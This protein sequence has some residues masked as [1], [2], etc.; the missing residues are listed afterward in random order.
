MVTTQ[1]SL[2]RLS[3]LV[4]VC[5]LSVIAYQLQHT[6]MEPTPSIESATNV[7][8]TRLMPCCTDPMTGFY[9]DGNCLTGQQDHGTH[10]VCAVM[11]QEFLEYTRSVGNDLTTPRPEYQFPGLKPGDLWC[12]CALRW[13]EAYKDGK[14][15]KVVLQSTHSKTLDYI[16]LEE[17][18][19]YAHD[20]E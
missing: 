10:T 20:E 11:T 8:G 16:S 9:R 14:A 2:I 19:R 6:T 1:R 7:Y 3:L 12:L 18:T 5:V 15:P 13:V 4:A 17:L